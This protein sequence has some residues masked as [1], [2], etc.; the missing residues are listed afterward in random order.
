MEMKNPGSQ[1]SA[2]SLVTALILFHLSCADGRQAQVNADNMKSWATIQSN[3]RNCIIELENTRSEAQSFIE[4]AEVHQVMRRE[5]D[6]ARQ[7]SNLHLYMA[8][9]EFEIDSMQQLIKMYE[10]SIQKQSN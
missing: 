10:D 4:S 5:E 1:V 9:I 2:L 3:L 6:K 7:L 8:E